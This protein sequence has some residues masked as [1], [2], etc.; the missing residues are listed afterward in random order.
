[1]ACRFLVIS[2]YDISI[3]DFVSTKE[4]TNL[5]LPKTLCFLTHTVYLFGYKHK[6]FCP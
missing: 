2:C 1:V 4:F 3:V 5:I 6:H